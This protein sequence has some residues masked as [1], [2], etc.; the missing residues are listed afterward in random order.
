MENIDGMIQRMM[1]NTVKSNAA[2]VE[3]P[4]KIEQP[5]KVEPSVAQPPVQASESK[6]EPV[7]MDALSEAVDQ[8]FKVKAEVKPLDKEDKRLTE[9]VKKGLAAC[10]GKALVTMAGTTA[11]L[12]ESAGSETANK[13]LAKSLLTPEIYGKIFTRGAC[14]IRL[15]L[16]AP[17]AAV[18]ASQLENK[19]AAALARIEAAE[20]RAADAERR[21]VEAE[22]R[23][24]RPLRVVG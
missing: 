18:I 1:G 20:Q 11:S 23:A 4:V 24:L 10:E 15:N 19:L 17:T 5:V 6:G 22:A 7:D 14:V 8:L 16:R 21:A 12:T 2:I 13:E 3:Q 9:I